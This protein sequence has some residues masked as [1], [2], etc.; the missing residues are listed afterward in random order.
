MIYLF[1]KAQLEAHMGTRKVK[2]I[3]D[4]NADG[5]ADTDPVNQLRANASSKVLSL[6]EVTAQIEALFNLTSGEPLTADT[7]P[8]EL[9]R[10]ALNFADAMACKRHPELWRQDWKVLMTYA[11]EEAA[12]VRD[13]QS[14]LGESSAPAAVTPSAETPERIFDDM[15]DF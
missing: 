8:Q 10:L 15:G 5:L 6:L 13:G 11:E 12:K 1:T 14:S 9:V 2:R 3:Y 4:E 7:V